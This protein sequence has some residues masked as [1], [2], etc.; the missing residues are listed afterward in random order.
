M[1]ADVLICSH[2]RSGGR[3]LRFMVA[4]YLAERHQ[5]GVQVTP[6]DVF[7]IVPDHVVESNRGYRAF[8]FHDRRGFPLLAVCHQPYTV[9]LHRN[10]PVIFLARNAYDVMVS[11]YFHLAREKRTYVGTFAE[12]VRHPRFGLDSWIEYMNRWT[13]ELLRHRDAAFVSYGLLRSDPGAALRKVLQ[14]VDEEPEPRLVTAAV[15]N[16]QALRDSRAIRTGQEG[17]FWDH[18]QPEE[19]FFIQEKVQEGLTDLATRLLEGIGVEIDPFPRSE[20]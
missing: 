9:D 10:Y 15:E 5:P 19:I 13:P 4:H 1:H 20:I 2:P 17:N 3:W 6:A 18:L 16:S 12:F 7:A 8:R 11:A 14:F